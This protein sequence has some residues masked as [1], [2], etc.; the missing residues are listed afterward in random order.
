MPHSLCSRLP[1]LLLAAFLALSS[2]AAVAAETAP[3]L[4][5]RRVTLYKH[6]VAYFERFG[7]TDGRSEIV[8]D[9]KASEMN[10]V[11]K[12]LTLLDRS[13][14]RV[15]GVSYDASDPIT[16]QL[17]NFAFSV[18]KEA[19]LGQVLDQFKGARLIVKTQQGGELR[20]SILGVRRTNR[21]G[22]EVEIATLLLDGG[23][24]RSL[25]L[26]EAAEVRLEDP[27]LQ[28][29]LATYLSIVANGQ[30]RDLRSLRIHPAGA[31]ELT[32][33]YVVEA[34]V[35]KSSY[36][37]VLD[38]HKAGEALLQGWAI[39]D[40]P[41]AED[42]HDVELSLVSGLPISFTQ[43]LYQPHYMR[44]PQV[45]LPFEL[46]LAPPVH[47]GGIV[48]DKEAAQRAEK[49]ELRAMDLRGRRDVMSKSVMAPG[50]GGAMNMAMPAAAPSRSAGEMFE[51]TVTAAA[52]GRELGELFEYKMDKRIDV[53]RNQSAM[54]PFVQGQV[55]AERVLLYDPAS[56][57]QNPYDAVLLTNSSGVTLDG[58]AITVFEGDRYVGE[59]LVETL[60][61]GDGRPVS[62]AMDL[63]TRV[64]TAFDSKQDQVYAVKVRRGIITTNSKNV[65]VRTYT[66]RSTDGKP[67][68][69]IVEHPVRPGWKLSGVLKPEETTA[70]HYR[71]RV[72]LPAQQTAKLA[73][74]EEFEIS[75]T[76]ALTNLNS[77][78]LANFARNKALTP[79]AQK[80]L[81]SILALKDRIA[82]SQ[83]KI[84]ARQEEINELHRD[85]DRLRQNLNNLRGLPGQEAQVNRYAAKLAEQEK[86]VE[87]MQSALTG[88]RQRARQLQDELDRT[89]ATLEI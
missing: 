56:G 4:P 2:L 10:D 25:V 86:V 57:R 39:V 26:T 64:T 16:K 43:N 62:F 72:A 8:L 71:F 31:R 17:E 73:V 88:E 28:R 46:A 36:R 45:A 85:Q 5:I 48:G 29:D 77:D 76:I 60:K 51:S 61:S 11:L 78:L 47:E 15:S 65:E 12:S 79:Q 82:D 70:Q 52:Q 35:W 58:G 38:P 6:G 34:P 53:P 42:W 27:R 55:K 30:R 7:S 44:R 74:S 3:P 75:N 32:V 69:L 24:L 50:V 19:S 1:A 54:L 59:A 23:E 37:L 9:F 67:K 83:R 33:G 80:Q 63:G 89:L 20:G 49:D 41:T 87:G 22:S 40:N 81:E 18:P 13:G 68:T 84:A 66:I 21:S 14:G